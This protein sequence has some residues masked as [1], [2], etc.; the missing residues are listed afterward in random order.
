MER[1]PRSPVDLIPDADSIRDRLSE[2]NREAELLRR[3]L[4]VAEQAEKHTPAQV[5]KP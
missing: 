2:L 4:R 3:L 5:E 1:I